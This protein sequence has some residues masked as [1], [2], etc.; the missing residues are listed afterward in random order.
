MTFSKEFATEMRSLGRIGG[1]LLVIAL[2]SILCF[3]ILSGFY[4][5]EYGETGVALRWGRIVDPRVGPGIHYNLPRPIGRVER[6]RT[7][8]VRRL[9]A[10][11]GAAKKDIEAFEEKVAPIDTLSFGL[12]LVPYCITGDKNV[13]H[14]KVIIQYRVSDPAPFLFNVENPE[15]LL[16][17]TVQN[18]ILESIATMSVDGVLT[19]EKL[20]LQ[21]RILGQVRE[22]LERRPIGVFVVS[23]EVARTRPPGA[24]DS[25][26]RDVTGAKEERMTRIHEAESYSR[27][28]L[29]KAQ[30]EAAYI[31]E[32]ARAHKSRKIA[33][34]EGEA[35]R[36]LAL[37]AEYAKDEEI[38]ARRLWLETQAEILPKMRK[39]IIGST[40]EEDVA[41]IRFLS[42]DKKGKK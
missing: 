2:A 12:F 26:F 17:L 34:A 23:V 42:S 24:V 18:A 25:A 4:R 1:K 19:T 16:A 3:W 31:L 37:A 5:I 11:F 7:S 40:G 20:K 28:S 30:S 39:F 33:H 21:S 22:R 14:A 8:E 38:T 27:R 15:K 10:G 35:E 41:K 13:V 6:I 32:K 9:L 36:F 29:H